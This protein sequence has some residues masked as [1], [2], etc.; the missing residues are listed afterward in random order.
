MFF[1]RWFKKII[2]KI[3][4]FF[5]PKEVIG[6]AYFKGDN[7]FFIRKSET[8]LLT[9]KCGSKR[10]EM[11]LRKFPEDKKSITDIDCIETEEGYGMAVTVKKGKKS[12]VYYLTSK[13]KGIFKT[14]SKVK[15]EKVEA[16]K[17]L[18][19][20]GRIVLLNSIDGVISWSEV[21]DKKLDFKQTPLGP[22]DNSFDHGPLRVVGTFV[23][24]DGVFVLYETSYELEGYETHRFGGA[25]LDRNNL[26]HQ[27]WRAFFDEVPFWEQF[28]SR[29]NSTNSYRTL[30]AYQKQ[31]DI[32]VYFYEKNN[33]DVYTLKLHE[34]YSRRQ[35]NGDG[36]VLKKYEKNPILSPNP[37]S[38]WE[39]HTVLNPASIQIDNITHLLY[40]AEGSAGLSTI[41]YGK[42]HNGITF[43]RLSYPVYTPRMDFEGVNVDPRIIK[44]LRM[45]SFRS[46][47][48]HYPADFSLPEGHAWHGVEDPRVTEMDGRIYMI[49]A[50]YNGY[51]MA[52]P[53][54]T[55]IDKE[56]FVNHKW[57]WKTP[58]PM[59]RVYHNHG[60]GNKNVVLHPEKVDGKYML[61]HRIWPHI[62]MDLVDDLEFGPG[63]NYLKEIRQIPAR[64]D[65]WDSH[66]VA[67]AAP[68]IRIDEGWLL[69]YQ[70]A[71]SQDRQYKVGAMILDYDD[72][73]K[74]LYRS[75]YP[76]MTP[77]Q[78]YENEHKFGVAYPCGAVVRDGILN[79]YYGGSDKYVCL[80]SAPLREFVDKLKQDPYSKPV[81]KKYK[82]I[83]Q[84]CT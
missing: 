61:F 6:T 20:E 45:G 2:N 57:N 43:D 67:V 27:H 50:A 24:P 32:L 68:P 60:E 56:D 29:T 66:K 53:A 63:K 47:Y 1:V 3:S 14:Q 46:G 37:S 34:P 77:S 13:S 51:Q 70:G 33:K 17:I 26:S 65:S 82:N 40:R 44:S 83:K 28:V 54:I 71:G 79:V 11:I 16:T 31:D 58:Q 39:N 22:R 10:Q 72:P 41:G 7:F 9:T 73:S 23:I 25:L 80:A 36:A 81:L 4:D 52:R 76:I 35:P 78:W 55:S 18:N 5:F 62:R 59:T 84:L 15:T 19:I 12:M 42:S 8:I 74:V 21:G 38:N 75:N 69:I 64:G 48:N 49:Y 30:G